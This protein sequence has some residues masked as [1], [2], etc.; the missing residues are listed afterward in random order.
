HLPAQA[1]TDDEVAA[2]LDGEMARSFELPL[3][4]ARIRARCDDEI[5]FDPRGIA[6]ENQVDAGIHV[7]RE[8]RRVARYV[9]RPGAWVRASEVVA[10]SGHGLESLEARRGRRPME[11][12]PHERDLRS[13]QS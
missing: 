12:H 11:L 1:G 3:D 6:V 10:F 13:S 4:H 8:D 7:A 2:G 5:V 9:G